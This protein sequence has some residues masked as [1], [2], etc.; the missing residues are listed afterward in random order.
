MENS[1]VLLAA[2]HKPPSK[3]WYGEDISNLVNLRNKSL[4]AGDLNVKN[5]AWS[6]HTSIP[7]GE[8]FLTLLINNDFQISAPPSPTHY[9]ARKWWYS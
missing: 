5:P 9:P 7:S 1:E 4:L 6:S 3:P 8:K 2:V